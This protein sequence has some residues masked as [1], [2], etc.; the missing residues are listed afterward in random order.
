MAEAASITLERAKQTEPTADG[1]RLR[2]ER[3]RQCIVEA[4]IT[5][6][7]KSEILPS[8][9]R[10]SEE[11]NVGLRTV[12]RHFEDMDS[13]YQE[14][15]DHIDAQI[16]PLLTEPFRS[17]DWRDQIVEMVE[18]RAKAFEWIMPFKVQA[19]ARLLQSTFIQDKHR[20]AVENDI[21]RL[22]DVVPE[23]VC[24]DDTLFHALAAAISFDVWH[25]LRTDQRRNPEQAKD[26]MMRLV[27]AVIAAA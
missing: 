9:E 15:A 22:H 27:R 2:A 14:V 21:S 4:L 13:L 23:E 7:R 1:R 25:R 10:V 8:A 24:A 5:L 11:A 12:F 18:R 17:D 6:I 20:C 3:S 16:Q 26:A 19:N